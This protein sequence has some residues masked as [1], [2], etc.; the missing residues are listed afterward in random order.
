MRGFACGLAISLAACSAPAS[1]ATPARVASLNLCTDELV[2]A[3]AAPGTIATV[4]HLSQDRRETPRW[5]QARHYPANDGSILSV[6]RY[7]PDLIVTMGGSGRDG[8]RLSAALG[9]R[10]LDL[11]FP[12]RLADVERSIATRARA[13]GRSSQGA[14]LLAQIGAARAARPHRQRAAVF[15]DKGARSLD[16]VSAGADWL[17]LAGYRQAALPGTRFDRETLMRLPPVTLLISSYRTDQYSR[18]QAL[19]LRRPGD[20]RRATDGRRWT[21]MGPDMLPEIARLRK[22]ATAG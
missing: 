18:S 17:A 12:S 2:L 4:T 13:L 3:L 21:C 15:I 6:A 22:M 5:R 8:A 16:P 20:T 19:P 14:S 1:A 7:N 9:A 11:P 10:F